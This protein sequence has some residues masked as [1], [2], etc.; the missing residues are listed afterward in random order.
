MHTERRG[1]EPIKWGKLVALGCVALIAM[2]IVAVN[3]MSF[4]SRIPD[5]E[6][7][8]SA[9]FQQ[10]VKIKTLRVAFLPHA[11]WQLEGVAIG[12][13][14]QILAP[15]ITVP[16][17]YAALFDK[18]NMTL[19]SLQIDAPV[20][21]TEGMGWLLFGRSQAPEL[22][23][24]QVK[25]THIK[26]D[27]PGMRLPV[28]DATMDIGADGNWQ[29]IGI[30]AME[31]KA[32]MQLTAGNVVRLE[33]K[34]N[35]A[36]LPFGALP[37]LD[38]LTAAGTLDRRAL[39]LDEFDASLSGGSLRGRASVVWGAD[40][41]LCWRGDGA[42]SGRGAA[43]GRVH[44]ERSTGRQGKFLAAHLQCRQGCGYRAPDRQLCHRERGSGDR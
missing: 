2:T 28:F 3:M 21:G 6:K 41:I 37:V 42:R 34:L 30:V 33:M 29:K 36:A 35:Q 32:E 24:R 11:Q 12:S 17:S 19:E 40:A 14:G 22:H 38:D 16:T 27:V 10:P 7:A 13:A 31:K 23:V 20:I 44:G 25:A 9:W 39:Q 5:F 43:V 1:R 15:R 8:A 18:S 26:L 4:E